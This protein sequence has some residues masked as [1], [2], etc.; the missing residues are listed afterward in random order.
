M[1]AQ[2]TM[3]DPADTQPSL[4]DRVM[5]VLIEMQA[6]ER[7]AVNEGEIAALD[8]YQQR[9]ARQFG[10]LPDEGEDE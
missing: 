5:A 4:R 6:E 8:A 1:E 3:T 9:K 2:P 7:Q 10:A